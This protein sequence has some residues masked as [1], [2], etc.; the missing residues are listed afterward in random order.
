MAKPT[1]APSYALDQLDRRIIELWREEPRI[2]VLET[3]R[4]LEVARGTVQARIDRML[5]AGV[6]S[7]FGPEL[8]LTQLGFSVLG[9]TTIEVAQGRTDEVVAHLATI[10]FVLEAHSIAGQ[11]DLLV[12][13]AAAT[14]EELM[15]VLQQILQSPAVD[16]A[17][18]AIALAN[19]ITFRTAPL[20]EALTSED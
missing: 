11:G 17:A 5:E 6:I 13:I 10:P 4:R 12:R 19:H 14:N 15:G 1:T 20:L 9:F 3:S 2:G 7:G 16:R 18:T 8:D